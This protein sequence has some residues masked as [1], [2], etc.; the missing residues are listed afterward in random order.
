M[1]DTGSK[2][3]AAWVAA[4][5]CGFPLEGRYFP[6]PGVK[7]W[8]NVGGVSI[9]FCCLLD[10]ACTGVVSLVSEFLSEETALWVA[11]GSGCPGRRRVHGSP[12]GG[13]LELEPLGFEL[14]F[15]LHPKCFTLSKHSVPV[16]LVDEVPGREQL[17]VCTLTTR[18]LLDKGLISPSFYMMRFYL[19]H[20]TPAP[21]PK[22]EGWSI[23]KG[24]KYSYYHK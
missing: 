14:Y 1:L 20:H 8:F 13:L 16:C 17:A 6:G 21:L 18:R 23:K 11:V 10:V 24:K 4:G 3:S 22:S 5:N 9:F 7:L 12:T 2:P 19:L 15:F